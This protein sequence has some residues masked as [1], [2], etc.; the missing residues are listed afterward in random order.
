MLEGSALKIAPP[1][2]DG[3]VL[4]ELTLGQGRLAGV[5]VHRAPSLMAWFDRKA[6]PV[7]VGSLPLKLRMAPPK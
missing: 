3:R 2:S 5:V 7:K 4:D 1:S 6:H